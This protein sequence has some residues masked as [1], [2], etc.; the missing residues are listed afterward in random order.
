MIR[1]VAAGCLG[2]LAGC[3]SSP[4][5]VEAPDPPAHGAVGATLLAPAADTRRMTLAPNWRFLHPNL[6]T[7]AA[8]P[9]YPEAQLARRLAPL[10]VCLDTVIDAAGTVTAV[11]PRHDGDCAP[12]SSVDAAVFF[13]A[14]RTAVLGWRYAPAMICEAP[15][16][17]TGDDA[18]I[19]EGA[20][21]TP[22]AVRL[23]YAFR[24]SQTGGRP[25]VERVGAP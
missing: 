14:A 1:W 24:F 21:E 16:G 18:C 15:P 3:A 10:V 12:S 25:E 23:S 8:L 2:I 11:A 13:D 22:T 6:D 5:V 17:Y 7:D 19:A 4:G 9:I 20:V